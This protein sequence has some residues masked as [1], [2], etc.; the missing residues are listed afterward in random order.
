MGKN[1]DPG[2]RILF[3]RTYISFFGLKIKI[4]K[5]FDADPDPGYCQPSIRDRGWKIS[6]RGSRINIPDLQHRCIHSSLTQYRIRVI[7]KS[8]LTSLSVCRIEF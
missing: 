1:P 3:L 5:F 6:N 8:F 7:V 4:L 2:F